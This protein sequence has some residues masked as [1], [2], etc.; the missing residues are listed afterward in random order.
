MIKNIVSRIFDTK[1]DAIGLAVFRMCY[2]VVLLCEISQLFKFRKII[3]DQIPFLYQGEIN[4]T[5]IF[6]LWALALLFLFF[7]WFTKTAA[8]L[9][10]IFG[11]VIFSSASHF[12]YHVFYTYVG[13]N[14]LLLF[15]PVSRVF[16]I[17]S[18]I[19]KIKYTQ[20]GK[21]FKIDRNVLQIN[22]LMPVYV[23][24][25]LIYFDSIFLKLDNRLWTSGLGVWLPS[26][27]PMAV[28]NDTS[29]LLNQ[30]EVVIFLGY[31]VLV[32]ETLFIF[33]FWF[34]RLRVPLMVIGIFF[35]IGILVTYPIPLFA[36]TFII[37]YLL[38]V[39][40]AFWLWIAGKMQFKN[41]VY[42]FYYDGENPFR[43]KIAAIIGH[44]DVFK[45]I[46]CKSVQKSS[47][48]DSH[49]FT[50]ED[51]LSKAHGL[52]TAGKIYS[53]YDAYVQL[54]KAMIYS[55]PLGVLLTL[56]GV[57][58]IARIFY[59]RISAD[60]SA[61]STP[62]NCMLRQ[63]Q[64][65]LDENQNTLFK[66]WNRLAVSKMAWKITI[67]VLFVFQCM[68]I[69]GS[70]P[71]ALGTTLKKTIG[72]ARHGVFLDYHFKGYNHIFKIVYRNSDGKKSVLP[73]IDENG[74]PGAY[75]SGVIWRHLTFNVVTTQISKIRFEKEIIPYLKHYMKAQA[76]S[77]DADFEFYIKTIKTPVNWEKD[78]LHRQ[79]AK[80]WEKVG[81]CHLSDKTGVFYWNAVMDTLVASE[82]K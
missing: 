22:Y 72:V 61:E 80:P 45:A 42:I 70:M 21:I 38:M 34:K 41:P 79:M 47:D 4:V 76:I 2:V 28:W 63:H 35:H 82:M 13:I 30:K 10:F 32:F 18:L 55:Y 46:D 67:V 69:T 24:I 7:G 5:Y 16:S 14:F 81:E 58:H 40:P 44:L 49:I 52:N 36:L 11:I 71:M 48:V 1:V 57:S 51:L 50:H 54:F 23:G 74:M 73:L 12:E 20:T 25:A 65:P 53:G 59:R 66:G 62:Q 60:W 17:D 43:N 19:T 39:P 33:L 75:T 26:S 6:G 77:G 68:L 37:I 29:L 64:M 56:P 15:I 31:F 3:Y 27:L 78:F 9:N 8:L